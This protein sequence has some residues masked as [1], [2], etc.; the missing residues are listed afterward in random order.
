MPPRRYTDLPLAAQTAYAELAERTRAFELDNALAGLSGSFHTLKRKG[1]AY[2]YF[3]YR[4]AGAARSRVLYVGPDN[5]SVRALVERFKGSRARG[6]LAPQALAAINLGC[7]PMAPKHFRIVKQLAEHG[8]FRAGAI[9]AG[10]HAF[11]A[12][13]NLLGVRWT[14]ASATLDVDVAHAGRN[15][16]V[17]LPADLKVDVHGALQSLE[18]GLLPITELSGR[19]GT[20]Y[21][22]PS[23]AELRV[24]FLTSRTR[25]GK[26]VAMPE[27]NVVLEPLKFMEFS[28]EG[29]TQG[30]AFG[31][32]GACTVNLPAP[33]RYAVH[34]LLVFGERPLRQRTKATKDLLQAAALAT[35]FADSGQARTFNAAWRDLLSRGRGWRERASQGRAA[36]IA[37]APETDL[38]ALWRA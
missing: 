2:W 14:D 17:A 30:C 29:T 27:L 21:R 28:L 1:R 9:L 32:T 19:I 12:Y 25:S 37:L 33:E 23:D 38:P 18:M 13:G 6:A 22:N 16:S 36:L 34:K 8:L 3:S 26:P 7:A 10:T 11:I 24:D 31:R 5:E 15:V 4:E 20:Q 35:W